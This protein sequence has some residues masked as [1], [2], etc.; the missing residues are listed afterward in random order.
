MIVLL[1]I[2][3]QEDVRIYLNKFFTDPLIYVG[4]YADK[5]NQDLLKRCFV[6][7]FSWLYERAF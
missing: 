7:R 6:G 4:I 3:S 5:A 2:I 1:L